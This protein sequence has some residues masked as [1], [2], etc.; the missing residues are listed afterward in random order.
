[1]PKHVPEKTQGAC[2]YTLSNLVGV[3]LEVTISLA[4]ASQEV[5][6]R[7]TDLLAAVEGV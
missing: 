5:T 7:I 6:E 3:L 1:M 2:K 4:I